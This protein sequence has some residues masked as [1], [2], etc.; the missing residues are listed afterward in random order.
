MTA[1]Y[2]LLLEQEQSHSANERKIEELELVIG[3]L[4][5]EKSKLTEELQSAKEKLHSSEVMVTRLHSAASATASI[6]GDESPVVAMIHDH[7]LESLTK[8]LATLEMKELNEKQRA[9]HAEN[10]Y[11]L[12]QAQVLQLEKRNGELEIKFADTAKAN[13]ELQKTERSLR[14]QLGTSIPKEKFVE[15]NAKVQQVE[16]LLY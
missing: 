16:V 7:Q 5:N 8:Q 11:K 15:A 10:K 14:D 3:N 4:S 12:V 6:T 1:R 2:R 9:D 13:L